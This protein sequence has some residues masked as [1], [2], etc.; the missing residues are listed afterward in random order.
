MKLTKSKLKR[1]IKEEL[2]KALEEGPMDDDW[3]KWDPDYEQDGYEV[4][5]DRPGEYRP[6]WVLTPD[7][8]RRRQEERDAEG[9]VKH[10]EK[11]ADAKAKWDADEEW[12]KY[13]RGQRHA[14]GPDAMKPV[15]PEIFNKPIGRKKTGLSRKLPWNKEE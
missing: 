6:R 15:D 8:Q 13:A 9:S 4:N 7:A 5:P 3:G 11:D 12:E 10:K 2:T 14:H 1:I